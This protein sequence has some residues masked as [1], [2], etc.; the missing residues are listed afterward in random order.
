VPE[1]R[2]IALPGGAEVGC[3]SAIAGGISRKDIV[4]H[5]TENVLVIGGYRS[6]TLAAG[7]DWRARRLATASRD[8]LEWETRVRLGDE[9][10]GYHPSENVS[11][12]LFSED[13]QLLFAA[14][15]RGV[16]VYDWQQV[17]SATERLPAPLYAV[18]GTLVRQPLYNSKMTFSV[19]HDAQRGLV[20]WSE[21]DGKLKFLK[22]T[23][24]EKGTLLALT[25]R[26][27]VTQ[28]HLF[29]AGDA[30][31]AEITRMGKSNNVL[32][33]LIVFDYPKLL[34]R[35]GIRP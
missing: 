9:E 35:A 4:W 15:D 16:R 29:A 20:L 32:T 22:L 2:I 31:V 12:L 7:P 11:Q 3:V 23:T 13:G 19:V 14:M 25:N 21:N 28:Q 17:C 10:S 26:H 30:L 5:P 8:Y 27:L 1:T 33:A 24:G 6:V 34:Q 18:Q